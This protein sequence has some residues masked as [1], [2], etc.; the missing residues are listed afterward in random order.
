MNIKKIL[1]F[2]VGP[3]ASSFFS[4]LTLPI[5]AWFFEAEDIGKLSFFTVISSFVI[6]GCTLGLDQAFVRDYHEDDKKNQTFMMMVIPGIII[7]FVLTLLAFIF[8][9]KQISHFIFDID[10]YMLSVSCIACFWAVLLTRYTGL[11]LRM[12]DE[13]LSFSLQQVLPKVIFL[14]VICLFLLV[15]LNEPE[16]MLMANMYSIVLVCIIY[17]ILT[18]EKWLSIIGCVW[19]RDKFSRMMKFAYPLVFGAIAYWGLTSIDKFYLRYYSDFSELGVYSV[20]TSFAAAATLLQRVFSIIWAPT[21]Y[22]WAA[23]GV[24]Y[25]KIQNITEL[26]TLAVIVIFCI[27]GSF[28]WLVPYFLPVEYKNVEYIMVLC[29]AAPLLYTLSEVTSIGIGI[30]RKTKYSFLSSVFAFLLN[31]ILGFLLIPK[32]GALGASTSTAIAFL[33]FFI[34][35]TEFS[36]RVWYAFPRKK[37]YVSIVIIFALALLNSVYGPVYRWVFVAFWSA[38][39]LVGLKSYQNV[40]LLLFKNIRNREV[41]RNI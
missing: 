35:R 15:G 3:L 1:F 31:L 11:T 22:K 20:A 13:A 5:L 28:A 6:M 17:L 37:M 18:K 27:S 14:I 34:L 32:Y 21:V 25:K 12:N 8:D 7:M 29:L 10:S 16:V 24:N 2:S 41:N 9:L 19:E 39:L 4:I 36:S 40:L 33:L 30:K 26:I 38:V 23:A